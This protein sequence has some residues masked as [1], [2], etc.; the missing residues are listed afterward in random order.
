VTCAQAAGR[1]VTAPGCEALGP[2][3]AIGGGG[4]AAVRAEAGTARQPARRVGSRSGYRAHRRPDRGHA[5]GAPSPHRRR[6]RPC[7]GV[8]D[9]PV[10]DHGRTGVAA[11]PLVR[12]AGIVG[13]WHAETRP[14][15]P[16]PAPLSVPTVRG[17]H[18]LSAYPA[19]PSRLPR[20]RPVRVIGHHADHTPIARRET[21]GATPGGSSWRCS[22][23]PGPLRVVDVLQTLGAGEDGLAVD[24]RDHRDVLRN[25]LKKG[26]RTACCRT[27]HRLRQYGR[28]KTTS[29]AARRRPYHPRATLFQTVSE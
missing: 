29:D 12:I 13:A 1:P 14:Q 23:S 2:R 9:R 19:P 3:L 21:S 10:A 24:Q 7:R 28:G 5:G 26:Q 17:H 4:A 11:A 22:S 8:A 25:C 20:R 16:G 15:T 18:D 27:S 6:Q